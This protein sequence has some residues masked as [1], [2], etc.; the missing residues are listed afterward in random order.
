MNENKTFDS[1]FWK[2]KSERYSQ[3]NSEN[4][5]PVKS[6]D[7]KSRRSGRKLSKAYDKSNRLQDALEKSHRRVRH[8]HEYKSKSPPRMKHESYTK[9]KKIE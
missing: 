5:T 9:V 4:Q 2:E 6:T 8:F 7:L 1:Y 3:P